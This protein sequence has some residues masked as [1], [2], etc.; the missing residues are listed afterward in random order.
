MGIIFD[1]L[2]GIVKFVF[3]LI[4]LLIGLIINVL[5]PNKTPDYTVKVVAPPGGKAGNNRVNVPRQRNRR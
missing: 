2:F 5:F 4:F 3:D 1:I